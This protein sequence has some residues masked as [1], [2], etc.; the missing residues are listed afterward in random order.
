MNT[1]SERLRQVARRL[2]RTP[3]F[4]IV[5][6]ITLAIAIG[7]NAVIFSVVNGIL[8]K[9]LPYPHPDE[10]IGVWHTAPGIGLKQLNMAAFL[11]FTDREQSKTLADIG[12]YDGDAVNITGAGQPEH[13]NG[14]DVTSRTLPLLGVQPALGR[15]FTE[16]DDTAGSPETI[17]ISNDY[18]HQKFGA[19][20]TAVGRI[21]TVDGRPRQIIGVLPAGFRFLDYREAKIYMPFQWD[22]SKV[23]LGSFSQEAIARLKPGVTITQAKSELGRLIPIAIHSFP[24][25]A[26][27]SAGIFEK[28]GIT[29]EL[30]PLKE[31]VVGDIGKT[32]WVV[33]GSILMVLLIACAN[34]ANLL[35]VRV[36]GRRQELAVRSALGANRTQIALDL[37]YESALLGFTGSLLGLALAYGALRILVSVAP[38]GLP[39]VDQVGI[40]LPVLLFTLAAALLTSLLIGAIPVLKYTGSQIN[41][42]LREGGRSQSE[43]R[44]R[45]RAR[46]TLVVVQVALALVLLICSGLMIRTFHA[47][48]TVDPGFQDP[49]TLQ[50]LRLYIPETQIPDKESTRLIHMEQAITDKIRALPGVKAAAYGDHVALDGSSN[51]DVLFAQD[52]TYAAT[53]L[54][55]VRRF[56]FITPGYLQTIGTPIVM[57]RDFTWDD[58]FNKLPVALISENMATE[59]WGSP[60]N[61]L[62]KRIRVASTDDW[63]EIIGIV[64]N[65]Y[66]DGVSQEAP[67]TVYWPVLMGAFEGQPERVQRG[68]TLLI[69]TPRAGSQ[70][71]MKEVEQAI[72]S[73]DS[74]LP[75]ADAR[76]LG[77]LN[78]RS[79]ARTSFTLVMLSVAASMALLL[80]IV[81]IYGVISYG[82]S[83]RTR[84]IGIRMALGAQRETITAIFVRSGLILTAIGIAFGLVASYLAAR[85]MSSLLFHVSPADTVT[86]ISISAII[87]LVATLACYFP[88]RRAATVDPMLALRSE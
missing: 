12:V 29:S 22:R 15:L 21:L 3:L 64:T 10:L 78:Q 40:D 23:K 86:Y 51:N 72:W 38:A 5:T 8:L 66:A 14:L 55:P 68:I 7:A 58:N 84:E 79:M 67:K 43:S 18:W 32:L 39:R 73:V 77:L 65:V 69:R 35:L 60:Q 6:L 83:Q 50:T 24:A 25:P 47:L 56:R 11:Y 61:A 75:L 17:L 19:D 48:A 81:G 20:P 33:M 34:I 62:H 2:M 27:F 52:R 54:P 46:N 37:F 45:H 41:S 71:F 59:Y 70:A 82:V 26:G 16:R 87:A 9:P 63:R 74:D 44:D 4:T 49:D 57:G 36:E 28:A 85:L 13:V 30:H 88:S 76:T 31:D 42:G 80:G 53:D 1:F